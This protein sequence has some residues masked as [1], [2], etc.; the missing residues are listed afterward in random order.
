MKYWH[1]MTMEDIEKIRDMV[2]FVIL[3]VGSVEE[4]GN[5]LPLSTDTIQA[6]A[7]AEK[8]AE[9]YGAIILPPIHYGW[10]KSLECF[11]GTISVSFD[12]LRTYVKYIIIGV[13]RNGFKKLLIL[14]SHA[15]RAHM[16]ALRLAARDVV[17]RNKDMRIV[18][19]SDYELIYDLRGKEGIP[20][21]DGHAGFMETA[22]ILAI[23][24]ELVK[25]EW[26]FSRERDIPRFLVLEDLKEYIPYGTFSDP[27]GASEEIGKKLNQIAFEMVCEV[28]EKELLS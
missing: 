22:R 20:E 25:E 7:I 14:S 27:L 15:S 9:K 19:L 13:Y 18:V 28:V 24:P 3:P 23:R 12:S 2:S 26:K 10:T 4:H 1:E 5:H 11:P 8:I 17:E 21:D 6:M 16:V